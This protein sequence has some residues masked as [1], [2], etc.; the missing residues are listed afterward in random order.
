LASH[1]LYYPFD[2]GLTFNLTP[3]GNK[4]TQCEAMALLNKKMA[5][6][7]QSDYHVISGKLNHSDFKNH[8]DLRIQPIMNRLTARSVL[9]Q[10]TTCQGSS[11]FLDAE[12]IK[13]CWQ[14]CS[15]ETQRWACYG[16][17]CNEAAAHAAN[18]AG[19]AAGN[20]Q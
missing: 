18:R 11:V 12:K 17:R 19:M 14:C 10:F 6:R 8:H 7:M 9:Y 15:I 16:L 2:G 3:I 4:E 1:G 13:P 5:A 20:A